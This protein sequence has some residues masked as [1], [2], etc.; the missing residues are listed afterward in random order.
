MVISIIDLAPFQLALLGVMASVL[1][2]VFATIVGKRDEL[3]TLKHINDTLAKNRKVA[4][5]NSIS[6]LVSF[7]CQIIIIIVVLLLLYFGTT[8][9]NGVLHEETNCLLVVIDAAVTAGVLIWIVIVSVMI[10]K[11][12]NKE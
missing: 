3:R 1:T 7:C 4:L 12:I 11:K 8:V 6:K 10:W 5:E 9:L 2:L